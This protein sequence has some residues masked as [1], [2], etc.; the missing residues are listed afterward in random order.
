MVSEIDNFTD[1][2]DTET[3]R[4]SKWSVKSTI[5][6]T[7]GTPRPPDGPDGQWNR[8]FYWPSGHRDPHTI[9]MVT[10]I[11]NFTDH[12]DTETPRQSRWSVKSTI[13]LTIGTPRPL[14]NPDGQWNRQFYWP[15]GHRDPYTIRMVSE[16]DNFTDHR[17]TETPRQSR[18]S[19]KSSIL[20]TI[21]TPRPPDN[22]DGQ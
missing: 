16:I 14:H 6:L 12:R 8:R 9:Q 21:G 7:I 13:L 11:D 18:W 15:S 20:L 22:P 1:H 19:V 2:R 10:E 4:Q 3:P 17:D 5:L